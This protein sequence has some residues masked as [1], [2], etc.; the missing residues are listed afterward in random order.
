M[1]PALLAPWGLLALLSVPLVLL[2]DRFARRRVDA[3]AASLLL[4][5]RVERLGARE[6]E[7]PVPRARRARAALFLELLFAACAS[8]LVARPALVATG[9]AGR[10]FV[11]VVDRSASTAVLEG[12]GSTRFAAIARD[13]D[14]WLGSLESSDEVVLFT[15]PDGSEIARGSPRAVRGAVPGA[16][17]ALPDDWARVLANA[18]AAAARAGEPSDP[19]VVFSDHAPAG[20]DPAV[21]ASR[22]SPARNAGIVSVAFPDGPD[23]TPFVAVR[24][25]VPG[26]VRL[27][28]DGSPAAAAWISIGGGIAAATLESAPGARRIG[29]ALDGDAL[30][31][32]DEVSFGAGRPRVVLAAIT[33]DADPAVRRALGNV[34]GLRL[35]EPGEKADLEIAFGVRPR[36]GALS[37]VLV[38][39]PPGDAP[40]I[41]RVAAEEFSVRAVRD[42]GTRLPGIE[43]LAFL[44]PDRARAIAAEP[45]AGI[46]LLASGGP[47]GETPVLVVGER[48]AAIAFD[49]GESGWPDDA[50]W[51]VFWAA[52]V[53]RFFGA[54]GGTRVASAGEEVAVPAGGDFEAT[55]VSPGGS[56]RALRADAGLFRFVPFAVGLHR[57]EREDGSAHEIAVA[58]LSTSETLC[59][60]EERRPDLEALAAGRS[61]EE[62][63]DE[64]SLRW[65]LALAAALALLAAIELERRGR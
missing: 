63:P 32:D 23:G 7:S 38:G 14:A 56:R 58:L 44:R 8:L 47:S 10:R 42:G 65:P 62:R 19:V 48:T 26:T 3:V 35:A 57:I 28:A 2:L 61:R 59:P 46:L 40:G 34:P 20:A 24:S 31:L 30:A 54:W 36:L 60:G 53:E 11:A 55:L 22:G 12:G 15:A 9:A 18:R 37:T 49:P 16:P 64:A 39:A 25:T 51:P 13:L 27:L 21:V 41:G 43:T 52:V 5:R 1:T 4:L 29:V 45:G 33:G 50:T 6:T 17:L